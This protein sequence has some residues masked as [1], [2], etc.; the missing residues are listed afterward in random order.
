MNHQT[1]CGDENLMPSSGQI[2]SV[3]QR[4]QQGKQQRIGGEFA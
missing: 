3:V 1:G 4:A 2:A